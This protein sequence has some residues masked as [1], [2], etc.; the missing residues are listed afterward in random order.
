MKLNKDGSKHRH[1][2]NSQDFTYTPTPPA[3]L[4]AETVEGALVKLTGIPGQR[5]TLLYPDCPLLPEAVA[6]LEK[7]Q[8]FCEEKTGAPTK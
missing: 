4:M 3:V 8:R 1:T 5:F 7:L 6:A 2:W